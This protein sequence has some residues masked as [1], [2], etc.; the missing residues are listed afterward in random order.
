MSV[1]KKFKELLDLDEIDVLVD[2]I[3]TS[4]HIIVSDFP[5]TIPQGKSSF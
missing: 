2:E 5:D 3:G 4:R 1:V